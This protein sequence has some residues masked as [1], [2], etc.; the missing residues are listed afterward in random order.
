[1]L[2]ENIENDDFDGFEVFDKLNYSN[3][4]MHV[5]ARTCFQISS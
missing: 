3:I 5:F 4:C 1:M 2:L